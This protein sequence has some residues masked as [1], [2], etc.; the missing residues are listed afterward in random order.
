MIQ[1][2]LTGIEDCSFDFET[3]KDENLDILERIHSLSEQVSCRVKKGTLT[4]DDDDIV[5]EMLAQIMCL[6]TNILPNVTDQQYRQML[7]DW[8]SYSI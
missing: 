4:S 6:R 8:L 7:K 1:S 2:I 3:R 5:F